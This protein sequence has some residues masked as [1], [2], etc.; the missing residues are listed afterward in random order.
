M[1]KN[2]EDRIQAGIRWRLKNPNYS[3]LYWVKY[4]KRFKESLFNLGIKQKP[5]VKKRNKNKPLAVKRKTK[6][7]QVKKWRDKNKIKITAHRKVFSALRNGSLKKWECSVCGSIKSE[8]HHTDYLK[9]L[10]V[11]WLCKKHHSI[12]DKL[13]KKSA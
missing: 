10:E 2:K 5:F 12:A 8:A 13:R 9:P 1:Y 4:Q 7:S 6:Y 11:V 3:K